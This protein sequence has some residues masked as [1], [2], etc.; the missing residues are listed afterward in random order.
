MEESLRTTIGTKI[1]TSS[2]LMTNWTM[3][4]IVT[5]HMPPRNV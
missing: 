3:S 1:R 2:V 5:D 4:V